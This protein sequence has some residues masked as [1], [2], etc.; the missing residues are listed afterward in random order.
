MVVFCGRAHRQAQAI[1][2]QWVHFRNVLDQHTVRLQT[3]EGFGR[4]G[5]TGQDHVGFTREGRH[6]GQGGQFTLQAGALFAQGMDEMLQGGNLAAVGSMATLS[7]GSE[8]QA[9]Q[10]ANR[11]LE[12]L[13]GQWRVRLVNGN[14]SPILSDVIVSIFCAYS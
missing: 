7:L 1:G 10:Y 14:G 13:G 11:Y 6:A 3:L 4:I 5:H 12:D 9:T 8:Q 2:Q